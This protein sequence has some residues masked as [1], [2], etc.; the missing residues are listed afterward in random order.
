MRT[1]HTNYTMS[2]VLD[3]DV[4]VVKMILRSLTRY[5][6]TGQKINKGVLSSD[7]R[8]TSNQ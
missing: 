7:N 1:R 3:F 6:K 4:D 2:I 8:F 5:R